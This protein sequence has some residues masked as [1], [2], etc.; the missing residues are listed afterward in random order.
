MCMVKKRKKKREKQKNQHQ[1]KIK[2]QNSKPHIHTKTNRFWVL[3]ALQSN[4]KSPTRPVITFFYS[5]FI[6]TEG[7]CCIEQQKTCLQDIP[8]F[9]ALSHLWCL[10]TQFNPTDYQV[11]QQCFYTDQRYFY[12]L[13]ASLDFSRHSKFTGLTE[14]GFATQILDESVCSVK[15][16]LDAVSSLSLR[17]PLL[18]L[19]CFRIENADSSPTPPSIHQTRST[20]ICLSRG[21]RTML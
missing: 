14:A 13:S 9:T 16:G 1:T 4:D 15:G 17:S 3:T 20:V 8:L 5:D 12:I 2:P 21:S 11:N 10:A 19:A 7:S 18:R 6:A